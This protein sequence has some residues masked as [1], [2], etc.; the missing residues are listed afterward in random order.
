MTEAKGQSQ[1]R[2]RFKDDPLMALV[3]EKGG[4]EPRNAGSP[5]SR[6]RRRR[7]ILP[8]GLR[9]ECGPADTLILAQ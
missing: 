5:R 8:E 2:E 7:W 6:T 3:V 9:K 1:S 4:Q